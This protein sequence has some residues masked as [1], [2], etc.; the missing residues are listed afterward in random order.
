MRL[1]LFS[2]ALGLI[3]AA[4]VL[5]EARLAFDDSQTNDEAAHLVAGY[6]YWKL[7]DWRLNPEHPPLSKLA[8]AVPLLFSRLKLQP[9]ARQWSDADEFAIGHEFLYANLVPADTLL[10][11]ARAMTIIFTAA[12]ILTLALWARSRFGPLAGIIVGAFAAFD[13]IV[14]AHGHYI[15]S[16]I[17]VTLFYAAACLAWFS[18]LESGGTK[19]LL[20]TAVLTGLALA[21]K[22]SAFLLIPTFFFLW[23]LRRRTVSWRQLACLAAI[24]FL[25]VWSAYAFDIRPPAS[26]PRIGGALARLTEL[27]RLPVPAY[28]FF[29]G[30]HLQWRHAHGGHTAYLLGDLSRHG[31]V[32]YF[33]VAFLV[34]TPIGLLAGLTI[35][36]VLLALKRPGLLWL[37]MPPLVYFLA[38]MSAPLNIGI[39][40][41]LP[42]YPFLY[43]LIGGAVW[44]ASKAPRHGRW[45]RTAIVACATGAIVESLAVYP[46]ALGFFNAAAGGPRNGSRYLLDSNIDWG[47]DLKRLP[48]F[49]SERRIEQPCVAYFGGAEPAY[50]GIASRPVPPLK[51]SADAGQL[52]CVAV[53]SAQLLLGSE[54][55]PFPVLER[56]R[57]DAIV[58]SSLFVFDLRAAS[59]RSTDLLK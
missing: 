38:S 35:S 25:I 31:F 52:R 39:R 47:Q 26:D 22:F 44:V 37:A 36:L 19:R 30:M 41:I 53:I 55:H 8:A 43:L 9:N 24:P 12:L 13:P 58:G 46:L 10:F 17:P 57:P 27:A 7:H 23:M 34:K 4:N 40:H 51:S 18:W 28:Y 32:S 29:R 5:L 15:T 50:Y 49:L 2:L 48:P 6:S 16:D 21:T 11:R 3:V 56:S 54:S 20:T 14:L 1:A 45:V 42:I 59:P 33:P